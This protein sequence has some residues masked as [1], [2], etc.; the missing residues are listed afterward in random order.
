[1]LG[2]RQVIEEIPGHG[3]VV[4]GNVSAGGFINSPFF[5]AQYP[6]DLG[7]E[8]VI[9]C[10]ANSTLSCKVRLIFSDFQLAGVSVMEV[11]LC[12]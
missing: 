3:T 2:N 8:Y 11:N 12:L 10:Q 1:M 6:R 5:P 4:G 9:N 7:A